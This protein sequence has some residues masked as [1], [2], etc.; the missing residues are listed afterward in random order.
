M[1]I[2]E[3]VFYITADN[4]A[5]TK[6]KYLVIGKGLLACNSTFVLLKKL[7]SYSRYKKY[8]YVI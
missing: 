2:K 3:K 4:D 6:K 8:K 5:N 7:Q 1:H